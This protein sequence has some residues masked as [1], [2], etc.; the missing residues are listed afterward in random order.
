MRRM[1]FAIYIGI[2]QI[3]LVRVYVLLFGTGSEE[4]KK[5]TPKKRSDPALPDGKEAKKRRKR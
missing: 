5:K 1:D 2:K 3:A 4:K